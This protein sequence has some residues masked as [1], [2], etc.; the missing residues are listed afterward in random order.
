MASA[1]KAAAGAP[2][3]NNGDFSDGVDA[4]PVGILAYYDVVGADGKVMRSTRA[5]FTYSDT[6]TGPA[7]DPAN[8]DYKNSKTRRFEVP[9]VLADSGL[10]R[11]FSDCLPGHGGR[12]GLA[13]QFPETQSMNDLQLMSWMAAGG[14]V[15]EHGFSRGFTS[16]ALL[17]FTDKPGDERPHL[18]IKSVSDAYIHSLNDLAGVA[19]QTRRQELMASLVHGG[20]RPKSIYYDEKGEVGPEKTHYIAKFNTT[21]D[22]HNNARVEHATLELSKLA[23]INSKRTLVVKIQDG[24]KKLT[25]VYLTE[26]YDRFVDAAGVD[27]RQHKASML[28]LMNPAVIRSQDG[29]D[30]K[31][32]FNVIRAYSSNPDEDCKEMMRRL[33]F[34]IAIN[35]TDDHLKNHEMIC[36]TSIDSNGKE[37]YSWRLA[38]AFDLVPNH[39]D[40]PHATSIC[41][42][43]NGSMN[44]DFMA[45]ISTKLE[46]TLEQTIAIRDEVAIAVSQW[47]NIFVEAG[48]SKKD[49]ESVALAISLQGK[50]A[51]SS[52]GFTQSKGLT[53]AS[54]STTEAEQ[55]EKQ[56]T[57]DVLDHTQSHPKEVVVAASEINRP[58]LKP[59]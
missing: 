9:N 18:S 16:G 10:F 17:F 15:S 21:A 42:L 53:Y 54:V 29:A 27:Q 41:G 50:K 6:Y 26:R 19:I 28:T 55:L 36:T 59:G 48:C 34:N 46:M 11:V 44:D 45:Y 14:G 39:Y 47:R 51:S 31:D 5:T 23:G 25:D 20:I 2:V 24:D 56:R 13:S 40:Y 52:Y 22:P 12:K 32:I 58:P 57:K 30:Y 37:V 49:M 3:L 33:I 7:L 35:N 38:P 4:K 1:G 43:T 8:L